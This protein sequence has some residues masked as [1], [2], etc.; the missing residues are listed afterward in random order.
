[1]ILVR[2]LMIF[3]TNKSAEKEALPL[4]VFIKLYTSLSIWQ[5]EKKETKL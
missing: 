1:M 3:Q 2:K 5:E 4:L